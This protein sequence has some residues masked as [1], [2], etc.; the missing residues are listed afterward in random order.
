MPL[1]DVSDAFQIEVLD[2]W[3]A[4]SAPGGEYTLSNDAGLRIDIVVYGPRNNKVDSLPD[5]ATSAVRAWAKSIGMPDSET[6]T[7]MTPKGGDTPRAFASIPGTSRNVYVGFFF[8][9]KSFVI[10]AGSA[11]LDDRAGF[12]HVE[13]MLWSIEAG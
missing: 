2:G 3:E 8:F 9:K 6:L 11:P 4:T 13:R 12:S 1:L 5:S 10:A 7:V